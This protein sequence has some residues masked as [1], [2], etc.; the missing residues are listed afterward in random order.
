MLIK[1][2]VGFVIVAGALAAFVAF[3]PADTL[4]AGPT[5]TAAARP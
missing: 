1:V 2:A 3:R 5:A 4:T